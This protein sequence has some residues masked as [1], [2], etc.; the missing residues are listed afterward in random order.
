MERNW[1]EC[2]ASSERLLYAAKIRSSLSNSVALKHQI[3]PDW[4]PEV[5]YA[6]LWFSCM[7]WTAG[8][9]SLHFVLAECI[10]K[11]A[12]VLSSLRIA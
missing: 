3:V 5:S 11:N 8:K 9:S 2:K 1:V 12:S 6:T 4:R 10:C 7:L